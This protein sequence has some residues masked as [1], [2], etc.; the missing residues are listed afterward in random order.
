M[1]VIEW[2]DWRELEL[3]GLEIISSIREGSEGEK[4]WKNLYTI[5]LS[6]GKRDSKEYGGT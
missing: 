4:S 5:S 6:Q 2:I 3:R 1:G